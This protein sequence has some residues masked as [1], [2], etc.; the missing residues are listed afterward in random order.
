[1][2]STQKWARIS[3][4]LYL[5]ITVTGIFSLMYVPTKLF[6]RDDAAATARNI[7]ANEALFR[8]DVAVGVL[9]VIG[10]LFLAL[11]LYRLFRDV[12]SSLATLM[13]ILVIIQIPITFVSEMIQLGAL[14]FLRGGA[15]LSTFTQ[16]QREALALLF[17]KL[18]TE[19]T[20]VTEILWGVWL[21]P[22][23]ALVIRS[24][25]L[26][27]FL[28]VWLAINGIAYVILSI[29]VVLA[30]QYADLG[31]KL[32]FPAMMGEVVFTLWLLIIG[33]RPLSFGRTAT[34]ATAA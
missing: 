17:L 30:P 29:T 11:A 25:F 8:I 32:A 26:P 31:F 22:L 4:L 13:A 2:A 18:N 34:P 23:A 15:Y 7:L 9:S 3:G 20:Y 14:L 24:R 28:G 21:F 16:A 12:D 6:V 10:F 1:M 27:R 19:G 33:A 5:F